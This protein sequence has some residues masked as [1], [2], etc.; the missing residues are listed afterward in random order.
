MLDSH[1]HLVIDEVHKRSVDADLLCYL[2]REVHENAH[3][4]TYRLDVTSEMTKVTRQPAAVRSN[5]T[6]GFA[7]SVLNDV[8]LKVLARNSKISIVLMSATLHTTLYENYFRDYNVSA[9][10]FVGVRT[11]PVQM[12]YVAT[13]FCIHALLEATDDPSKF[14]QR[15]NQL[16]LT[17]GVTCSRPPRAGAR[18]SRSLWHSVL[19]CTHADVFANSTYG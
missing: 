17:L 5:C 12:K 3:R 19:Q 10:L 14:A 9:P 18:G 4:P 11:F 2:V 1:T 16:R 6:N 8:C 15:C 13:P 7:N